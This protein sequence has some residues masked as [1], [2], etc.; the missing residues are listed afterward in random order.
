MLKSS[1]LIVVGAMLIL[2]SSLARGDIERGLL[3]HWKMDETSGLIAVD[4]IGGNN[5]ALVNFS[6]SE[7]RWSPGKLSGALDF[8]DAS[9]VDNYAITSLPIVSSNYTIAFWLNAGSVNPDAP[10]NLNPRLVTPTDGYN[11]WVLLNNEYR[12]RLLLR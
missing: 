1:L 3:H 4:S 5:A 12:C 6:P 7:P 9:N 10:S 2:G 8:G 11:G